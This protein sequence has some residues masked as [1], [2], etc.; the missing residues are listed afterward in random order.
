LAQQ[1]LQIPTAVSAQE[2]EKLLA[3]F[4]YAKIFITVSGS[5]PVYRAQTTGLER[6]ALALD[7]V[8]TQEERKAE[9]KY[10]NYA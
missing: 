1:Q 10:M 2:F 9:V 7:V 3:T 8:F 5:Y 6:G 4:E